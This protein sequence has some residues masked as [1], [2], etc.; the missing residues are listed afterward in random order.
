LGREQ[1]PKRDALILVVLFG[2]R[3]VNLYHLSIAF[4]K[5]N[6]SPG[7]LVV[8]E[9]ALFHFTAVNHWLKVKMGNFANKNSA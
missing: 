5:N 6:R 8:K 4:R 9:N 3:A 7:F 2:Q 1:L